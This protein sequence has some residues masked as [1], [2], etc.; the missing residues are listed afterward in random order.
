[1]QL[2][3]STTTQYIL[4]FFKIKSRVSCIIKLVLTPLINIPFHTSQGAHLLLH[5]GVHHYTRFE[6]AELTRE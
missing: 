2:P 3:F 4:I 6:A 1:M 5:M